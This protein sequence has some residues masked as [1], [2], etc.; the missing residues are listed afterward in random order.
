MSPRLRTLRTRAKELNNLIPDISHS[1]SL[2]LSVSVL[3]RASNQNTVF[4]IANKRTL[5]FSRGKK[6]KISTDIRNMAKHV[7]S[8]F[9]WL[10]IFKKFMAKEKPRLEFLKSTVFFNGFSDAQIAL[11]SEFLHARHFPKGSFI[12]EKGHPGAAL[13]FIEQGQVVVELPADEDEMAPS[14]ASRSPE[15]SK[16]GGSADPRNLHG[17]IHL[18]TLGSGSFLGELALIDDETRSASARCESDCKVLALPRSEL[19][20]LCKE[21]PTLGGLVFKALAQITST[22]LKA[23]IEKMQGEN[24]KFKAVVNG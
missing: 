21:N 11:T 5:R 8:E 10:D 6:W 20:R 22:R 15:S 12:F 7:W 4:E 1:P 18:A 19:D 3:L 23:T 2:T 9:L 13:Y 24:R 14:Q 17:T 16:Q